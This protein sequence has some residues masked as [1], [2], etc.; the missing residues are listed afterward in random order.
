[1]DHF[2]DTTG[3]RFT[4]NSSLLD[5]YIGSDMYTSVVQDT[6]R[7]IRDFVKVRCVQG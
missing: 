3:S 7:D 5:A 2:F 6:R 4:A 1:M